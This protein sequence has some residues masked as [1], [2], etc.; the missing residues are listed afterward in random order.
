ME[1]EADIVDLGEPSGNNYTEHNYDNPTREEE[2][3]L[4]RKDLGVTIS[5]PI[6]EDDYHQ[7]ME[8]RELI[9][10]LQAQVGQL[11]EDKSTLHIERLKDY[12]SWKDTMKEKDNLLI[13]KTKETIHLEEKLST[14]ILVNRAAMDNI[15]AIKQRDRIPAGSTSKNMTQYDKVQEKV[16]NMCEGKKEKQVTIERHLATLSRHEDQLKRKYTVGGIARFNVSVR[17]FLYELVLM[18][19]V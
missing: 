19:L 18:I 13:E 16:S 5:V 4:L 2:N 17:V 7:N 10:R 9:A 11:M 14:S 1:D 12:E 8:D 3:T 6:T 15:S